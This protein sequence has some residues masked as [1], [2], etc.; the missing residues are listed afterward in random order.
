MSELRSRVSLT[1]L[2]RIYF[3]RY[4]L[5]GEL[6]HRLSLRFLFQNI[7]RERSSFF[8]QSHA[9]RAKVKI[10]QITGEKGVERKIRDCSLGLR[11]S[12]LVHALVSPARILPCLKRKNKILL[13]V[14]SRSRCFHTQST[15][16]D[17]G[18]FPFP[19][20][21]TALIKKYHS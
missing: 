15:A 18:L 2:S 19:P 21:L 17:R 14:Y 8:P 20:C 7:D 4:A 6:A 3:S 5:N 16:R 1:C 9:R 12:P 11:R 10:M 13:V